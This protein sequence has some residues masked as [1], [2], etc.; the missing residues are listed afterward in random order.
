MKRGVL[1]LAVLTIA[2]LNSFGQGSI[3]FRNNG[4]ALVFVETAPGV[5]TRVPVGSQFSV[6]LMFAPDGTPLEAFDSVAVRVGAAIT[7]G[8]GAGIF[9]GGIR[10]IDAVTPAGGGGLL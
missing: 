6:E 5:T 10:R 3:V 9:D 2:V 4:L 8:P 7:F 1:T